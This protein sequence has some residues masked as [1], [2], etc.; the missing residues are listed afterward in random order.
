MNFVLDLVHR[1]V[2][3]AQWKSI[4]A[5]NLKVW[6]S[7]PHGDSEFCL[8]RTLGTGRKTSFSISLSSSKLT[9]SPSLFT[10]SRLLYKSR[11]QHRRKCIE[12]SIENMHTDV[13][14]LRHYANRAREKSTRELAHH[15]CTPLR[16]FSP[17]R[18]PCSWP[19]TFSWVKKRS[20]W[21]NYSY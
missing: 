8:C 17:P 7:I 4:R 18:G 14:L 15:Q 16:D 21:S 20:Y 3:V 12:N 19:K 9:I 1:R 6:G 10:S 13:R 2:S 11:R 5:R